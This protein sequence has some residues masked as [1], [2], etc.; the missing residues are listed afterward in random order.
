[1]R[2]KA[3]LAV[4]FGLGLVAAA[5]AARGGSSAAAAGTLTASVG[6]GFSISLTQNGSAVSN[7][8]AGTY[9]IEVSDSATVHNFHLSGAGVNE[10]TSIPNTET[11]TWTVTFS[12]G[13]YHYQCDMHPTILHGDFTVGQGG[14]TT[15]T[16][17]T[18]TVPPPT[19][20]AP[21][22]TTTPSTT[23]T[24]GATTTTA[25]T[26]VEQTTTTATT[27][28][29][30]TTV[31]QKRAGTLTARVAKIA[32][33]RSRITITLRLTMPARASADL[34]RLGGKRLAHVAGPVKRNAKLTL[35]PAHVLSPGR[36]V[37]RLRFVAAGRT[38]VTT[39]TIRVA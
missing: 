20:T 22:T 8:A 34:F 10:T 15:S 11:D 37:V 14:G 18:T 27:S 31:A 1:M 28:V 36:Y 6:P 17:A 19:T 33:T 9:T 32:T 23:T 13:S 12:P 24:T 3:A 4:I 2:S 26:T 30:T 29:S 38:V 7:L 5:V 39:R 16:V 35:R 25:T 21:G